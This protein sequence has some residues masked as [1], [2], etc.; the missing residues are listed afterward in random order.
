MGAKVS[1]WSCIIP[2]MGANGNYLWLLCMKEPSRIVEPSLEALSM[3]E[4]W[5]FLCRNQ[6]DNKRMKNESLISKTYGSS[7][8]SHFLFNKGIKVPAY[9][10]G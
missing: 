3:S 9:P 4:L 1:K 10:L 5:N 7:I 2:S 8:D 6:S